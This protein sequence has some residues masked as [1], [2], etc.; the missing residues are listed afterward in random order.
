MACISDIFDKIN[1]FNKYCNIYH[2]FDALRNLNIK[3]VSS[4]NNLK[5]L[6]AFAGGR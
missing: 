3:L 2:M 1:K 6:Q 5:K 4:K